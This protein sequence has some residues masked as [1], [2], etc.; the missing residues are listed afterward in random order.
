MYALRGATEADRDWL[1]ALLCA[2]MRDYVVQTW[3][4]WGEAFQRDRFARHFAPAHLQ[5]IGVDGVDV[6]MLEV[7]RESG[8]IWLA[9]IQLLPEHQSRGV[10]SAVLADLLVDAADA[11]QPLELQVLKVNPARAFYERLGLRVVDETDTHHVMS[12]RP[13]AEHPPDRTTQ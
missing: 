5:I 13:T 8:R 2:S 4:D 10:G 9:E 7:R 11:A 6:G 3:G 12:T 1:Y